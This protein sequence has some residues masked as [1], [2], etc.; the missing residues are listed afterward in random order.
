MFGKRGR[1][2]TVCSACRAAPVRADPETV[3]RAMVE[4]IRLGS[5]RG[6]AEAAGVDQRSVRRWVERDH[7]AEYLGLRER[8]A[9]EI[10]RRVVAQCLESADMAGDALREMIVRLRDA[11]PELEP[12][13]LASAARQLA[14]VRA[15]ELDKFLT[16]LGRPQQVS[17]VRHADVMAELRAWMERNPGVIEVTASEG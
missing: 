17:E 12:K 13:E 14:Q 10:E 6:A 5:F 1:A 7:R 2:V 8:W 16:L 3:T 4:Y 11:A 15:S 9:P